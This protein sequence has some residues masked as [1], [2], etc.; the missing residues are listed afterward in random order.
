M[1]IL[2]LVHRFPYPPTRGD[3]IRSWGE[4]QHL[5]RN[6]QIW[7]AC[8]DRTKPWPAHLDHARRYCADVAVFVRSGPGAL[9]RGGLSLLAGRTLTYG[10]FWDQRLAVQIQH[11]HNA[12][13]FDAVLTF[14]P[15]MSPYA[16]L[17]DGARRVLDMNDVESGKWTSYARRSAPP[18]SWL[19]ALE[20]HQLRRAEAHWINGHDISL[21][22]NQRERHKLPPEIQPRTAVVRTGVDLG[23]YHRF[24]TP[25]RGPHLTHQPIVGCLGSMSYAPNIRAVNWFGHAIW[26]RIRQA[27]PTARWLIVG[28]RPTR[29]VRKWSR[30]PGVTVTG[31]VEDVRPALRSMRAFVVPTREEIGVQTKLIEAMAAARA[32]IVTP[33]AAAGLDYA[34]PPPFA[35]AASAEEFA[36]AVIRV[37]RDEAHARALAT[38]ARDVAHSNYAAADQMQRIEQWLRGESPDAS[39]SHACQRTDRHQPTTDPTVCAEGA[40]RV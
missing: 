6:H 19:Y 2:M 16:M 24:H 37:L 8:T 34:D 20:A 31:F 32:C 28:S 35:I 38:R 33:Q 5:S 26:P 10:Y 12:V 40:L 25:E 36:V 27:I 21:L 14:S 1:K 39:A 11:W 29:S 7:L 17:I 4:V 15:A 9:F 30:L 23:Q 13:H 22:V 18:L 3:C